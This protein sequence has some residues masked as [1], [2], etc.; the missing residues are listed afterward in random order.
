MTSEVAAAILALAEMYERESAEPTNR[1][2]PF[3]GERHMPGQRAGS[4][5]AGQNPV[6]AWADEAEARARISRA[7]VALATEHEKRT[8]AEANLY[9]LRAETELVRRQLREAT[10]QAQ[11]ANERTE[12]AEAHLLLLR[13]KPSRRWVWLSATAA[14]LALSGWLLRFSTEPAQN[15]PR[16]V[17]ADGKS[18]LDAARDNVGPKIQTASEPAINRTEAPQSPAT[19]VDSGQPQT[20]AARPPAESGQAKM[21]PPAPNNPVAQEHSDNNA[22]AAPKPPEGQQPTIVPPAQ[23]GSTQVKVT[24]PVMAS[25]DALPVAGL[26]QP[27]E[28]DTAIR[29]ERADAAQATAQINADAQQ[30]RDSPQTTAPTSATANDP[31]KNGNAVT[32][33][34]AVHLSVHYEQS[35]SSAHANAER[36]AAL[37]AHAGFGAS[38]VLGT[39]HEP[40]EPVVRYFFARDA[41]AAKSVVAKLRKQ[42]AG[43]QI[44]DCTHYTHKPPP[45]SIQVWPTR[46]R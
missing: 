19:P 23:E 2:R 25:A 35:S 22:Q 9:R 8:V 44:E 32:E 41:E 13:H 20:L 21:A 40:K 15:G 31:G 29:N 10:D 24:P 14:V 28:L 3:A 33:P 45:G 17:V 11:A 27:G 18:D 6:H 1:G 38:P 37:L 42:D 7:M 12:R 34:V 16:F 36:V 5:Q 39:Q 30:L 26:L 46:V 43:W 4:V